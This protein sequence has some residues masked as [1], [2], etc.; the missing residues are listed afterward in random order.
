[1]IIKNHNVLIFNYL[2]LILFYIIKKENTS[3]ILN[4]NSKTIKSVVFFLR[5]KK[6]NIN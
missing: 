3:F 6:E 4:F 2:Y 5:Q 1:M